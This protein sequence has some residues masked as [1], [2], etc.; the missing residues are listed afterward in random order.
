MPRRLRWWP[1]AALLLAVPLGACKPKSTSTTSAPAVVEA[2][3]NPVPGKPWFVDVTGK[4]GIDFVHF[5]S[6]TP[7][8][9]IP[10]V[11]GSG[12]GWIDYD[13]DGWMDLFCVQDGPLQ[14]DG[15]TPPTHKLYRNNGD[16]TF[17]DV[18]TQVGLDKSG[19]GMGCAVGDFDNDGFDDL[20]VTYL[21][22]IT[23]F[24]NEP[25]GK[26]G[27][28]FVDVT[29]KAG[30]VNPHWGTSCG[31]GTSTATGSSTCTCAT[32]SKS[33]SRTTR[34]ARTR[35][36]T[37]CMSARRRCSRRP[38]TGCSTTTATGRSRT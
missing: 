37:R 27:R 22:H 6:A 24:H 21:D 7:M 28:H 30:I 20:V 15:K 8:H 1:V 29:E 2:Q 38:P 26:G 10:E 17:T 3:V 19:Y 34:R 18:T 31:W 4:A 13:G 32:T 25:D 11:M 14:P 16:G 35:T 33:T 36:C 9:Y 23:L 12:I 5:D